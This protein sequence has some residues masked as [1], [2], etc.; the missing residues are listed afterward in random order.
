MA[1]IWRRRITKT[2]S[3]FY[4]KRHRRWRY[5]FCVITIGSRQKRH[6]LH[7]R[8]ENRFVNEFSGQV[9]I[10]VAVT[11]P[12]PNVIFVT[13]YVCLAS[14]YNDQAATIYF[15]SPVKRWDIGF[16]FSVRPSDRPSVRPSVRLSVCLSVC[17]SLRDA[18]LCGRN[19]CMKA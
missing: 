10:Q 15:L 17:P 14:V 7:Q 18:P 1:K 13:E 16:S 11:L 12:S 2:Q 8:H 4:A 6:H 9:V 19:F 3:S 5:A